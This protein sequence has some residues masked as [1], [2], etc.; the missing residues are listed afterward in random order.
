[1]AATAYVVLDAVSALL[2]FAVAG[3][4]I[5]IARW[6]RQGLHAQ[7]A[8]GFTL[9]GVGF[10]FVA[11]G[12]A[13]GGT[14]GDRLDVARMLCQLTGALTLLLAYADY[15]GTHRPHPL[16]VAVGAVGGAAAVGT[17]LWAIPPLGLPPLPLYFATTYAL[18]GVA[19]FGC[20]V[21]SGYGWHRRP[22]WG[23]AMVPLAFLCWTF[24]SY[25]WI[26]I[27]LDG[28]DHFLP[29]V[30]AWRLAAILLMLWAMVRRPRLPSTRLQDAPA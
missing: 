22:T 10:L 17:L 21:L 11:L 28:A 30:Y 29:V 20:T 2:T 18:M 6:S 19:F 7:V 23:R 16:A 26:F 9:V 8:A 3:G 15:H 27:T 14:Q 4:F 24:S 25:T 12:H 5:W 13:Q 1:M